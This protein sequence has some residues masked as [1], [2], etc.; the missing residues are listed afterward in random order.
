MSSEKKFK[1]RFTGVVVS[2]KCDKTAVVLVSRRYKH[3]KYSKYVHETKKFHA[4]DESNK[5]KIGD[6]VEIIESKPYSK[7]KKWELLQIL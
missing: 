6:K 2:D 5:A 4:H 1:R 3:A 7:N